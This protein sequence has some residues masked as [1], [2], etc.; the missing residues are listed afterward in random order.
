MTEAKVFQCPNCGSPLNVQGNDAETKCAYCGT[1]VIV[2]E[3][4]RPKKA[5]TPPVS[6]STPTPIY[7]IPQY[8][9]EELSKQISTVGKVATGIAVSTMVAPIVIT[10][11]IFCVVGAFVAFILYSVNSTVKTALNA[12][13]P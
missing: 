12:A 11:A 13:D 2:P 1:M 8:N 3:E 6:F 7:T 4:L 10:V 5:P 9:D